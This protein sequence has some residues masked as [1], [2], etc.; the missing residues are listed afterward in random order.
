MSLM[1]L[2]RHGMQRLPMPLT[3]SK[4]H[5]PLLLLLLLCCGH[6]MQAEVKRRTDADRQ[7]QSHFDSEI[8][9]LQVIR[10][11]PVCTG[12]GARHMQIPTACCL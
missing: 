5:M 3:H 11:F 4:P 6:I 2:R 12:C 8:K 10:H 9:A 1:L 7:I